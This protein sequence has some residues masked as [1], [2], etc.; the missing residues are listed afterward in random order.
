MHKKFFCRPVLST[1]PESVHFIGVA[2]M[3][4]REILFLDPAFLQL[5]LLNRR[6]LP[7]VDSRAVPHLLNF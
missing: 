7:S 2:K 3:P 5:S 6:E 4:E 1:P